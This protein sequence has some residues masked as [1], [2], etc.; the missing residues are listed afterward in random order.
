MQ[1]H[2]VHMDRTRD[3]VDLVFPPA[4]N[5]AAAFLDR[6]LEEGRGERP[7][8]RSAEGDVTYGAL[9]ERANRFGNALLATG[10]ASGDRLL[11]VVRD[12]PEFFYTFWGAIK[13]GIIPI[14]VN[15]FLTSGEYGFLIENSECA[16]VVHSPEL[17]DVVLFAAEDLKAAA[18]SILATLGAGSLSDIAKEASP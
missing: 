4:F 16:A 18:G 11:M 13:A 14:P 2:K 17:A 10:L 5:A 8:L 15:T 7:A 1:A 12:G 9:A 6:H 3:P